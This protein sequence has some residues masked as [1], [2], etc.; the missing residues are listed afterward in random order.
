MG[1]KWLKTYFIIEA[2]SD[3]QLCSSSLPSHHPHRF[4]NDDDDPS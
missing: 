1:L 2:L 4:A 3:H